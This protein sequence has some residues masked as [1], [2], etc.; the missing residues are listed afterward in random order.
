MPWIVLVLAFM[1]PKITSGVKEPFMSIHTL[2]N[3]N[4]KSSFHAKKQKDRSEKKRKLAFNF[5]L[6]STGHVFMK[7]IMVWVE[8]WSAL[9][10]RMN[11]PT[12]LRV[13]H[14]NLPQLGADSSPHLPSILHPTSSHF[15]CSDSILVFLLPPHRTSLPL[16]TKRVGQAASN[17]TLA[18]SL[19]P[20][21]RRLCIK[22]KTKP[23]S[24]A[25]SSAG[26]VSTHS[27][28]P[29]SC[30]ILR[31]LP[32]PPHFLFVQLIWSTPGGF[33]SP[34]HVTAIQAKALHEAEHT[35]WFHSAN[36]KKYKL[37]TPPFGSGESLKLRRTEDEAEQSSRSKSASGSTKFYL[38]H[39]HEK[40]LYL[41]FLSTPAE[42]SFIYFISTHSKRP[43][44]PTEFSETK[45]GLLFFFKSTELMIMDLALQKPKSFYLHVWRS[46]LQS[47][48]FLSSG[49]LTSTLGAFLAREVTDPSDA[50]TSET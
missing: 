37:H 42:M 25:P 26:W 31:M 15:A 28:A 4:L 23:L 8:V 32:P 49:D 30:Q 41:L 3:L 2:S 35:A 16:W 47:L 34:C 9:A 24:P 40:S 5:S 36:K 12:L 18:H 14:K 44:L 33:N 27:T 10:S 1:Q 11:S 13:N 22:R 46:S 7:Q 29:F 45:T 48:E 17:C 50:W 21:Q 39:L 20:A 6:C 38:G 19:V 43:Y